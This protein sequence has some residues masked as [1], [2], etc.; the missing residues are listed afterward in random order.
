MTDSELVLR[1]IDN[2]DDFDKI[3][4]K[5]ES[6]LFSYISHFIFVNKEDTEDILQDVFISVYRN[7]ESY[8]PALS[9]SSWIYRIAHNQCI[10][11]LRKSKNKY[12]VSNT[13][14]EE[15]EDWLENIISDENLEEEVEKEISSEKIQNALQKLDETARAVIVLRYLEEKSYSE[16]ADIIKTSEGNVA[17]LINRAKHKLMTI[18]NE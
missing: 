8:N 2:P 17:S 16:I 4:E 1:A 10:S 13:P 11:F 14:T 18:I 7:L 15:G 5:Y 12:I 3:V 6:K 9:F